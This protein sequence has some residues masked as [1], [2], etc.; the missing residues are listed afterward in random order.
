[1]EWLKLEISKVLHPL[2]FLIGS[3]KLKVPIFNRSL[4]KLFA[5]YNVHGVLVQRVKC[6]TVLNMS[7]LHLRIVNSIDSKAILQANTFTRIES[8]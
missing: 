1:M 2:Y 6:D 4:C 5:C 3:V 8:N 7:I